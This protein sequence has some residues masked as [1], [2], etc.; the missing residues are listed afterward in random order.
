MCY[1]F[2]VTEADIGREIAATGASTA[3]D[4]ITTHVKAGRCACE[5]KNPQ[6]TCCLGNVAAIVSAGIGSQAGLIALGERGSFVDHEPC[7]ATLRCDVAAGDAGGRA[8]RR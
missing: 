4:K 1:C 8:G 6:G 7:G 5:I 2:E 3:M